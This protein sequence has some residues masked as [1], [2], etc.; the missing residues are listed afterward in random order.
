MSGVS[1]FDR[2]GLTLFFA[3]AAHAVL[4][5]G[6]SFTN[7]PLAA[8]P[9]DRT[10]EI[11]VV[12]N[13]TASKEP[14]QADFLAQANQE[15]G[16]EE[17]EAVRPKTTTPL[18]S[19]KPL[20]KPQG[21]PLPAGTPEPPPPQPERP[22]LAT[23]S[24]STHKV[25]SPKE[26]RPTPP[27]PKPLNIAQILADEKQ[28]AQMTA[29]LDRRKVAYAKRPRRRTISAATKEYKYANY[30]DAWKRKVE[31]IGNLNYPDEA[32]RR[33]LYGN[34]ILRVSLKA[35]GTIEEIEVRKSSGHKLLDD[36]AIRI[37][38]LAAPYAPFPEEIRKETDVLDI[39]R[40]WQFLNTNRLFSDN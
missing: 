21:E 27:K 34:L 30:L 3:T 35:D 26:E 2:L 7:E 29:E 12:Q 28:I 22:V 8:P 19:D 18:P 1:S 37:V 15:G 13:R 20:T 24:P 10:L 32:R 25:P 23:N 31:K 14:E 4:I 38:R 6:V 17:M 5:L 39:V 36:A 11:M 16:G 9:P 40:T 33:K